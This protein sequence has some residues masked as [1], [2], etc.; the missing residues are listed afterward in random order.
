MTR[1]SNAFFSVA[2]LILVALGGLHVAGARE[3]VVFL[4]ATHTTHEGAPTSAALGAAYVVCWLLAVAVM[5]ILVIAGGMLRVMDRR[6]GRC[7][8]SSSIR[9]AG[10]ICTR[11]TGRRSFGR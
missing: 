7:T 3:H 1:V 10:R 11:A 8:C 9:S 6:R 5:P 2:L 4:T